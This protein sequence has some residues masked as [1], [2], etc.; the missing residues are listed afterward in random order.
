METQEETTLN[1]QEV[2]ESRL[3]SSIIHSAS[4][5]LLDLLFSKGIPLLV[6]ILLARILGPEEFGLYGILVIFSAISILIIENGITSSL[7]RKHQSNQQDFDTVFI[8]NIG[9]SLLVFGIV[10]LASPWVAQF[11]DKPVLTQLIRLTALVLP[12]GSLSAIQLALLTK[13]MKFKLIT[14]LNLP[15]NILGGAL[16]IF[17]AYQGYGI[18]SLVYMLLLSQS[19]ITLLLWIFGKW[20]PR[21]SF[22]ASL[23]KYHFSFGINMILSGLLETLFRNIYNIIIGKFYPMATL[24]LFERARTLQEYPSQALTGIA[25]RVSYPLLAKYQDDM[26]TLHQFFTG[27]IKIVFFINTPL[28]LLLAGIA[29]PLILLLLGDKWLAAV[30]YFQILCLGSLFYAHHAFNLNVIKVKGRSDLFLRLEVIKKVF[31]LVVVLATSPFGIWV[32]LWGMVA[33]TML[34]LFINIYYSA[35]YIQYSF[36]QQMTDLLV[37]LLI[38]LIGFAVSWL[39]VQAASSQPVFIQLLLGLLVGLGVMIGLHYI[40]N[41]KGWQ[42]HLQLI[43]QV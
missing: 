21:F 7:I 3:F 24:G 29:H 34:V 9:F 11:F 26:K 1:G 8:V 6:A 14:L 28:M 16:G 35:P 22:S 13:H 2:G 31:M 33:N 38:G 27:L 37:D 25:I 41:K 20:T 15:G 32:M 23:A 12:I 18:Y 40:F 43:K 5:T 36:K 4:W 19:I 30:P 10:Y 42:Q 39:I 17:L